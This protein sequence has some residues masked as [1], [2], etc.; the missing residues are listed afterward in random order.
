MSTADL[1]QV[2]A[3][4]AWPIVLGIDPG[5]RIMG[6]GAV[7]H[8]A[9]GPR[10]LAAGAP[11]L[12]HPRSEPQEPDPHLREEAVPVE[13]GPGVLLLGGH[14]VVPDDA[15]ELGLR[16]LAHAGG[17]HVRA[18]AVWQGRCPAERSEQAVGAKHGGK[19]ATVAG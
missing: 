17:A 11:S 4:L 18:V 15:P 12:P 14:V 6:Y 16:G 19:A 5:T 3:D 2:P 8:H 13:G 10:L 9:D 1:P 7:I